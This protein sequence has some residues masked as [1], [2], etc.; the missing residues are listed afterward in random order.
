M[1]APLPRPLTGRLVGRIYLERGQPVEILV[2]W[3]GRGPRNVMIRRADG[4]RT[5]RPF[6][7]LRRRKEGVPHKPLE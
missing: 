1:A 4:T 5:I 6:R 3:N 2:Q 7:G